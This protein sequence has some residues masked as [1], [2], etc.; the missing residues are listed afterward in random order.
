MLTHIHKVLYT[1]W[2]WHICKG[3]EV[4][5]GTD[6]LGEETEARSVTL[7][8]W[9]LASAGPACPVS[10][11][12]RVQSRSSDRTLARKGDLTRRGHVRSCMT[13]ANVAEGSE[14]EEDWT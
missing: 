13:Y 1:W 7:S 14:A 3:E 2:C 6:Q 8:D 5:V 10:S 12:S 4:G 9:T 11:S